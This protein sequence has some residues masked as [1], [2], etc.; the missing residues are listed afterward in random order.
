VVARPHLLQPARR[1]G[2]PAHVI[3]AAGSW[4]LRSASS[5][6]RETSNGLIQAAIALDLP[7]G[8]NQEAL[9]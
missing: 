2:H 3:D 7:E 4:F 1:P 5:R 6:L 8:L 9:E